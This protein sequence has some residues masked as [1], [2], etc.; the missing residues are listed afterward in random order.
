MASKNN[1][2]KQAGSSDAAVNEKYEALS[3]LSSVTGLAT[4]TIMS[5]ILNQDSFTYLLGGVSFLAAPSASS[6]DSSYV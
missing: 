5:Y 6:S 1:T 3:A 2:D 4:E